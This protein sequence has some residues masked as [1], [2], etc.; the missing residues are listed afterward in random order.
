MKIMR[1]QILFLLLVP[2]MFS[3][4][5]SNKAGESEC[6][7]SGRL[8]HTRGEKIILSIIHANGSEAV[9][10]INVDED[11]SFTF[12]QKIDDPTFFIIATAEDNFINLLIAPG[13]NAVLSGDIRRLSDTYSVVGSAG[14]LL[15]W[16]LNDHTRKNYDRLDSLSAIWESHKYDDNKLLLQDSLDSIAATIIADQKAFALSFAKKNKNSLASI[17]AL[18]Q[19]FGQMMMVDEFNNFDLFEEVASSLI[20][21][22][23]KNEHAIELSTRVKQIRIALDEQTQLLASLDTG[24][25]APNFTLTDVNSRE[26]SVASFKGYVLLIHFWGSFSDQSR[27]QNATLKYLS[28]TY[29]SKGL[30]ILSVSFDYDNKMWTDAIE[31]DKLDWYNVCDLKNT[32]SPVARLYN[33][34]TLPFYYLIDRDGIIV[35]KDSVIDNLGYN[36]A[37]LCK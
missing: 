9:D 34:E 22:Y 14:S 37:R 33:I 19:G 36:I 13:E 30:Q 25:P 23:P 29:R 10:S 17:F 27:V 3:C 8:I 31:K 1:I 24:K 35:A 15:L 28:K 20:A 32:N 16:E 6:I 18:Y 4:G 26:V 7:I 11:G 2:F 5:S 21:L 12:T